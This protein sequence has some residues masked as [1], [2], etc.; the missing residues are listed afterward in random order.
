M[1]AGQT[2]PTQGGQVP[3]ADQVLSQLLAQA[4]TT[5]S[6]QMLQ[7]QQVLA[8]RDAR[9]ADLEARA[10]WLEE[11]SREARRALAAVENGRVMRLLR[12]F[13]RSR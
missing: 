1:S 6:Q 8:Q 13:R 3:H 5:Q 11:Q 9:I 2:A 10:G 4:L 7:L 12:R